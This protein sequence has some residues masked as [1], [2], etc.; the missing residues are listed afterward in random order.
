M[1]ASI[2]F[3][4]VTTSVFFLSLVIYSVLLKAYEKYRE[5]Y[6]VRTSDDLRDVFLFV[7][8]RQLLVLNVA[9]M[10]LFGIFGFVFGGLF[11]CLL[12]ASGGFFLPTLLVRRY[13]KARLKKFNTQLVD[14]LNG[15]SGALRAGLTLQQAIEQ[16]AR[17]APAP[18]SQ[19]FGLF[20]KELKFGVSFED[21]F[22]NMARNVGSDDLELVVTSANIARQLGGNMAEMFETISTTV[23]ERFRLEGKIDALTSQGKLSG[24]II[25]ALPFALLLIIR[26]MRPDLVNPMM[27]HI[28]GYVLIFSML[29]MEALGMFFIQRIVNIDV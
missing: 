9:S 2:V 22:V 16:I 15:M 19:E 29:V 10:V 1:L 18:L 17:E 8:P 26:M 23:R 20:V 21:A 28:F 5:Y 14:A 24:W 4:L 11:Y 12:F 25:A 13:R 3:V 27:E 6:S 7:D